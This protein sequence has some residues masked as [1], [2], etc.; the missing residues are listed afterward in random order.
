M[1]NEEEIKKNYLQVLKFIK[2]LDNKIK[3]EITEAKKTEIWA[4]MDEPDKQGNIN[5]II[6]RNINTELV[7]PEMCINVILFFNKEEI[8]KNNENEKLYIYLYGVAQDYLYLYFKK[9][10]GIN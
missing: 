9:K 3:K 1:I 5:V 6:S 10:Y 7:N 4:C 2:K 8:V